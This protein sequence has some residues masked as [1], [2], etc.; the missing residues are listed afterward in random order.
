MTHRHHFLA[1][2]MLIGIFL[3]WGVNAVAMHYSLYVII[4]W[5]DM[6]MHFFGGAWTG[7]AA[8]FFVYTYIVPRYSALSIKRRIAVT[9]SIVLIVGL[10]W[11]LFEFVLGRMT[12]I[13]FGDITDTVTDLFLDVLGAS[14]V[15]A[16]LYPFFF[17]S[18]G[19]PKQELM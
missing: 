17:H 7:M 9:L 2:G 18:S 14:C 13:N 19:R 6:P 3:L 10:G 1:L 11:E 15:I 8:I 4:P 5:F 16:L 12:Y